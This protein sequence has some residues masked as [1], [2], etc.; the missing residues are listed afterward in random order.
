MKNN[1]KVNLAC[2]L[3][4]QFKTV[5]AKKNKPLILGSFITHLAVRLGVLDLQNHDLHMA[6]DMEFLD[7]DCL[8]KMGLVERV[9]RVYQFTLP[10]LV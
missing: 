7:E 1:V 10:G 3:A 6:Y 4:S 2:W 9:N 8:E 5:L